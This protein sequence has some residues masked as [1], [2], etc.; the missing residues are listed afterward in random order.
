MMSTSAKK[1]P[2]LP[3]FQR[4]CGGPESQHDRK[5]LCFIQLR[6]AAAD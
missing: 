2:T 4:V 5:A 3:E 1:D 6:D